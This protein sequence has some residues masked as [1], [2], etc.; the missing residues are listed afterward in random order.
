MPACR[1][2]SAEAYLTRRG[3]P[4]T[5]SGRGAVQRDDAAAEVPPRHV[6]PPGGLDGQGQVALRGPR[7]D[8]LG[9]VDVGVGVRRD[10]SGDPGQGGHEVAEVDL[11]E[12]A[13]HGAAEL[14]DDQ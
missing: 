12:R 13:V 1:H 3:P 4:E 2:V 10:P 5:L 8:R 6:V 7:L 14:A 11:A 9:E